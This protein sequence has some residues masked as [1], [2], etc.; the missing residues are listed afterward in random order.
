[1]FNRRYFFSAQCPRDDGRGSYS[2][3][4]LTMTRKSWRS[5]PFNAFEYCKAQAQENF[6][7]K[8]LDADQIDIQAFNRV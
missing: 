5:E 1:M 3:F 4:S 8:G 7:A 6:I 2:F